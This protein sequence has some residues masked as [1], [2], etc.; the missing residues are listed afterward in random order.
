[1]HYLE[2]HKPENILATGE[3]E[4]FKWLV[5]HNTLGYRVGYI[6]VPADHP[7]HGKG[8][9]DINADVHGGLT[10]AEAGTE[11]E[12][13]IGFDCAHAGDAPDPDLPSCVP[14]HLRHSSSYDTV[15]SQQFV[16]QECRNLCDQAKSAQP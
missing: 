11:G 5:G 8:Y 15:K 4:G 14:E 12:W 13:W 16:E 6:T 2:Q 10:Y 3:H 9:D 7:W 1:M